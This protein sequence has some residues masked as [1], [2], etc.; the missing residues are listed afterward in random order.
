VSKAEYEPVFAEGA[1]EFL[2]HLP[3]RRQRRVVALAQQLAT[4][5]HVRSDYSLPDDAGRTIEHLTIEDYV[6]A[7]WL[8]H[9]AREVRI[10]DIDD[11]S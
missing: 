2:L 7:Y 10:V 4:H 6:F 1:A 11:A 5:P 8:D 9:A 3:R